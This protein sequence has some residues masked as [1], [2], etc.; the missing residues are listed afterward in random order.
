MN[1]LLTHSL[2]ISVWAELRCVVDAVFV[3]LFV[4]CCHVRFD[5]IVVA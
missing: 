4:L 1:F 3:K 2:P 5:V